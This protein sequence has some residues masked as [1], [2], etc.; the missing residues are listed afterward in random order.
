MTRLAAKHFGT[1]LPAWMLWRKACHR[2]IDQRT[3]LGGVPIERCQRRRRTRITGALLWQFDSHAS[4]PGK[5]ADDCGADGGGAPE[6][7][8]DTCEP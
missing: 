7:A 6:V 2:G 1:S 5:A 4:R 3:A 8:P